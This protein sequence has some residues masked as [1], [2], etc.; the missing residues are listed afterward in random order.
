VQGRLDRVVA[1]VEARLG[2]A[3]YLAGGTFTA[4]DIM[5]VFSL[6]TMR[7]FQPFD[8]GRYPNILAYLQRI[9]ARPAYCR[10]MAK[11]DP[12]LVPMLT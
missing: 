9:G 2:E 7:L 12:D 6:T 1:L 11:G 8:L 4:A 10:A 3:D 5:S